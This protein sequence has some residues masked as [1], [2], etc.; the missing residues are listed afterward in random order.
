M[1]WEPG[2]DL[3]RKVGGV[4]RTVPRQVTIPTK[5]SFISFKDNQKLTRYLKDHGLEEDTRLHMT[6]TTTKHKWKRKVKIQ[7]GGEDKWEN[8]G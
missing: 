3:L 1:G 8:H 2:Q 7:K 6:G 5:E 4:W